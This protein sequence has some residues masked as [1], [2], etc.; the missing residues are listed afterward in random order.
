A[1]AG[2][3]C[4]QT[5]QPIILKIRPAATPVPALKYQLLPDL[6]DQAPGNAATLYFRS[7]TPEFAVIHSS[8]QKELN[9]KMDKAILNPRE[10][11]DEALRRV[12]TAN[13][14]RE[15]DRAARR[16]YCDWE[17]TPRLRQD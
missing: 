4:A 8:E 15:L 17:M 16:E 7:F 1:G 14:L 11:P 12:L 10:V 3:L 5:P 2:V 13:G 6:R 9:P